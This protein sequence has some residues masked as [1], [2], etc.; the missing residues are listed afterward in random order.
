MTDTPYQRIL[1]AACEL[2]HARGYADVGV[3][4]ICDQARVKKGSFYHFFPSKQDLTLTVLET[5]SLEMKTRLLDEAFAE[6]LPPLERLR[7]LG[8]LSYALQK[9]LQQLTGH[10]AGCPIANLAS[11]LAT[12]DE[13]IRSKISEIFSQLQHAYHRTLEQAVAAGELAPMDIAATAE[14]MFAYLEGVMLLAKTRNDPE[15]IRKLL[16]AM[17]RIRIPA[18][19]DAGDDSQISR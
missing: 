15:I 4:A 9:H 2:M 19:T 11:E 12:Q 18:E 8:E 17:I 7:R 10:V 13:A 6:S 14:A 3:A 16:P 5:Q 1:N